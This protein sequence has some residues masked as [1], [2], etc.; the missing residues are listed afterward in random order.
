M[1]CVLCVFCFIKKCQILKL[2]HVLQTRQYDYRN[3]EGVKTCLER[4]GSYHNS[5]IWLAFQMQKW[6]DIS[7]AGHSGC[8]STS[9]MNSKSGTCSLKQKHH[10]PWLVWC[11]GNP[12]RLC[13]CVLTQAVDICALLVLTLLCLCM[14]FGL[15]WWD[16][17]PASSIFSSPDVVLCDFF[18]S[19]KQLCHR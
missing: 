13:Q 19:L 11:S 5:N 2:M 4:G 18:F 17:W 3:V 8:L 6:N 1:C 9:K 12:I 7:K 15:K 16:M 14:N 10:Y